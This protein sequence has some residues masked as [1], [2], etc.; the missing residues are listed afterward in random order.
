MGWSCRVRRGLL[1]A[2]AL[3]PL[4]GCGGR[5][6]PPPPSRPIAA[7][8]IPL[9]V[10]GIEIEDQVQALPLNFIDR[11]RSEEL[12]AATRRYV[13]G[14]LQAAGGADFGKVVIEQASLV[15]QPHVPMGGIRGLLTPEPSADLAGAL[16]VR[17]AVTDGLGV[18]KAYARAEVQLKRPVPKGSTVLDR[19]LL[20]RGVVDDMLRQLD[21]SLAGSVRENLLGA[22]A[23]GGEAESGG[24][25]DGDAPAF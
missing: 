25:A 15:E 3:L 14:R 13:N 24:T 1:A 9:A 11:R 16:A 2:T 10:D 7:P 21:Q 23:A 18:E 20:A 17:V 22:D 12:I 6:A 8:P 5:E 4:A 19:D